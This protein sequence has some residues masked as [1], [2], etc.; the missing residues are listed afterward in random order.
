MNKNT[1][2]YPVRMTAVLAAAALVTSCAKDKFTEA[3]AL[4]LEL[5]RLRTEDSIRVARERQQRIWDNNRRFYLRVLDSLDRIN[6]GGR[7]FYTVTV[8]AAGNAAFGTGRVEEMEG[9][10][11]ATVSVAQYGNIVTQTTPASG[12]VTVE[13]RSGSANVVVSAPGHTTVNYTV[14]LTAD[15][16]SV[17]NNNLPLAPGN[18]RTVHVGNVIPLFPTTGAGTATVRGRAYI[19]T[20]LTNEE[21]EFV[22][23]AILG[24]GTN[25]FTANININDVFRNRYLKV[26]NSVSAIVDV[27]GDGFEG[28][29]NR[30]SYE[31][32]TTNFT[33]D[34]SGNYSAAIPASASGLPIQLR[35]SQIAADRIFWAASFDGT[36][37]GTVDAAGRRTGAVITRR[38]IYGPGLPTPTIA[39][40]VSGAGPVAATTVASAGLSFNTELA[41][42]TVTAALTRDGSLLTV[43]S[44]GVTY[45]AVVG[46]ST[47][48]T[49]ASAGL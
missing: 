48:I 32:A 13:L 30:I 18:G 40:L 5:K 7:V 31:N 2:M 14:N 3:N 25:L 16:N 43:E 19:E 20:N 47:S 46:G 26:S 44:S 37:L 33:I 39:D 45:F 23:P 24:A 8:V 17:T 22:T 10:Q 41:P 42:A 1:F 11:N 28:E 35:Y 49:P 4:D 29:I 36:D 15:G 9:L 34:G 27:R 12:M 21:A 38:F 6:A